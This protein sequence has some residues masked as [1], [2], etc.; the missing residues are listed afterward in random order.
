MSSSD[1]PTLGH[2]LQDRATVTVVESSGYIESPT[3]L[4]SIKLGARDAYS[5]SGLVNPL[6][7]GSG[8]GVAYSCEKWVRLYF[9][10]PFTRISNPRIWFPDYAPNPG[11]ELRIGTTGT[12]RKPVT[13]QS[14]VATVLV[15]TTS[16]GMTLATYPVGVDASAVCTDWIVL[17]A[18]SMPDSTSATVQSSLSMSIAWTEV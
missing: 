18:A 8:F 5:I 7:R 10:P 11:W 2:L 6:V 1:L 14:D 17:Q 16:P 4:S 13:S 9:Q 3:A 15:A 12:Y